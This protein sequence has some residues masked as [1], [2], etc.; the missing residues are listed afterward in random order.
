MNGDGIKDLYMFTAREKILLNLYRILD[1][2]NQ[3]WIAMNEEY[4]AF[5][6]SINLWL[7]PK[8]SY[9]LSLEDRRRINHV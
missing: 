6:D 7:Y 4:G 5:V 9:D 8:Q 3:F 1:Y 2:E